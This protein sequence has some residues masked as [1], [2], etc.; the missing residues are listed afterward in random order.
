[1]SVVIL[2][3]SELNYN[4]GNILHDAIPFN[5]WFTKTV[6]IRHFDDETLPSKVL[7]EMY[8]LS[9]GLVDRGLRL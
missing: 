1:M 6:S 8:M 3:N 7:S 2:P 4:N 5:S 9:S